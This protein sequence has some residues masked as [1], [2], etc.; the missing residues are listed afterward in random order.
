MVLRRTTAWTTAD[1][2]KPRMSAHRI[3]QVMDPLRVRA[4]PMA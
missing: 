2:A 3:S 1:R 4:C